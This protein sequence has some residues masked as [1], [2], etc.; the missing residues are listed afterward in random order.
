MKN[1]KKVLLSLLVLVSLFTITN[2][3]ADEYFYSDDNVVISA[4][5]KH[6]IF[7]AGNTVAL[8]EE[9]DGISFLA[10]NLVNVNKESE[11]VF[12]AGNQVTVNANV[13]KDVFAAG[14]TVIVVGEVG[15]DAYL[16]GSTVTVK[17]TINGNL[18]VAGG[19]VDLS[20]VTINGNVE[21]ACD[22]ITLS[23]KTVINGKLSYDNDTLLKDK[24]NATVAEF[25]ER[26]LDLVNIEVNKKEQV[27]ARIISY[28]TDLFMTLACM[29]ILFSVFPKL[30]KFVIRERE[31]KEVG[32]TLLKG[33]AYLFL[34]PLAAIFAMCLVVPIPLS[35]AV[36]L[37][38]IAA[39][40]VGELLVPV[41]L[42]NLILTKLFKSKDNMYLSM[43]IGAVLI[44][45]VG[46]V[47]V[48]GGLFEFL[49]LLL[50]LGFVGELFK[51]LKEY[52]QSK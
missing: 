26:E 21:S 29:V 10:G 38:Y 24:E 28:V 13:T 27:K 42:G 14:S 11:Y 15:R 48:I 1:I 41:Y 2:V 6:S 16:A 39:I 31:A 36:L 25:N 18:F 12:A 34:V 19:F 44:M 33:F 4:P 9:V 43:L 5:A 22:S 37:V 32:S 52:A 47:P 23:E 30:Y 49:L 50:G 8:N 17:G 7:G 40:I 45:L 46:F 51:K 35:C 3:K 20:D